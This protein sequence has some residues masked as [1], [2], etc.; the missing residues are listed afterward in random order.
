MT[1]AKNLLVGNNNLINR[2]SVAG[3]TVGCVLLNLLN[4]LSLLNLSIP[5]PSFYETFESFYETFE[6]FGSLVFLPIDRKCLSCSK[7]M[8]RG[9]CT[10]CE[11]L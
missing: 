7:R 4:L 9:A 11:Y 5:F 2:Y 6:S 8:R 10:A 1:R 3:R